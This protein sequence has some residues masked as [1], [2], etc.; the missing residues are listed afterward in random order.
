P[1]AFAALRGFVSEVLGCRRSSS[2]PSRPPIST[3]TTPAAPPSA[4]AP[5]APTS[6]NAG[7]R[8]SDEHGYGKNAPIE[9]PHTQGSHLYPGYPASPGYS[10]DG[11]LAGAKGETPYSRSPELR[12]SHK[13]AERK[14]RKEMKEL[15][16]ELRDSLPVDRSLKTSKWEI[17]S[18][19]VDFIASMKV[20]QDELTKEVEA[21]RQE[22]ARLRQ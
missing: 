14:R 10:A 11:G 2:A 21:L 6:A 17:L 15:F 13:L 20:D 5:T 8:S 9:Q 22:V 16:D 18:K 1:S 3:A 7:L 4:A 12:V 19:A